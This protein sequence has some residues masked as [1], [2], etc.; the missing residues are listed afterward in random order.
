MLGDQ[1]PSRLKKAIFWVVGGAAA[2]YFLARY[3]FSQKAIFL[4]RSVKPSGTILQP[5]V[6]VEIAVQNPT[7]QRITLKSISGSVFVNDK[8]LANVSS[9]GD[10]IITGNS[11]SIVKVTARPSGVGVFQSVRQ[12]LT[13]PIGT[14]QVRFSGS[15]NV[16]GINIPIEET[17]TL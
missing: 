15:A 8:Y 4:L 9:F 11:E 14:I 7:N 10:Q 5:T 6:T 13:Q 12:L 16:D 2:L 3:S 1:K 17:K